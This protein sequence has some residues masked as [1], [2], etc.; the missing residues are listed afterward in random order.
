MNRTHTDGRRY[1]DSYIRVNGETVFI[2][3]NRDGSIGLNESSSEQCEGCGRDIAETG[4]V[5][6]TRDT[7]K[8][9]LSNPGGTVHCTE[10]GTGYSIKA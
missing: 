1:N 6:P 4:I 8:Q 3:V 2:I 10:C 9:H 5:D 7:F